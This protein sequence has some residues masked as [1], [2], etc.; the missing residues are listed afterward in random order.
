MVNI[1]E[2]HPL[3]FTN[4][5]TGSSRQH[6]NVAERLCEEIAPNIHQQY[7]KRA[8]LANAFIQEPMLKFANASHE[9]AS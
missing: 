5:R 7:F 6:E 9:I 3:S 8:Q 4:N 1:S 2:S